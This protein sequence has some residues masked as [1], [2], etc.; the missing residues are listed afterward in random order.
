V[1][2]SAI[3]ILTLEQSRDAVDQGLHAGGVFSATVPLVA[4]FYGGFLDLDVADPAIIEAEAV[5]L[6]KVQMVGPVPMQRFVEHAQRK[7]LVSPVRTIPTCSSGKVAPRRR[8]SRRRNKGRCGLSDSP[9]TRT[10]RF[11]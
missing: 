6:P 7:R 10:H 1:K 5:D 3:R 2:D 9:D 8:W 4:L 11:A